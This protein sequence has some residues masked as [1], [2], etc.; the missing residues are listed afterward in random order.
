[1]LVMAHV[2][3]N[4]FQIGSLVLD[5]VPALQPPVTLS[6][7]E[8]KVW[9]LYEQVMYDRACMFWH[10]LYN[11]FQEY[12]L[13]SGRQWMNF[14]ATEMR[15]FRQMLMAAKVDTAPNRVPNPFF[16]S[17][18]QWPRC[19]SNTCRILACLR[20]HTRH[21]HADICR[22]YAICM[23]PHKIVYDT[24]DMG[25][26]GFQ[27]IGLFNAPSVWMVDKAVLGAEVTGF[28]SIHNA[29]M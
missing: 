21:V 1:M 24:Q 17:N 10:F 19:M 27:K 20:S 13:M 2:C 23:T 9:C 18:W 15:F 14:Y 4:N 28:I 5:V 3:Q 22:L 6:V 25:E 26:S 7:N 16:T 29:I 11:I 8:A 12:R